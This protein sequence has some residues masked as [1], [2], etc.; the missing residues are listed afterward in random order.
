MAG[1]PRGAGKNDRCSLCA[2][3]HEGPLAQGGRAGGQEPG[4]VSHDRQQKPPPDGEG[5][6]W[7]SLLTTARAPVMCSEVTGPGLQQGQSRRSPAPCQAPRDLQ[8]PR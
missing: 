1:N 4:P 7:L 3:G 6:C 5:S 8:S 2:Q